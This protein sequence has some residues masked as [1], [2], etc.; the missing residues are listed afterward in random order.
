MSHRRMRLMMTFLALV[1]ALASN[2]G[3]AGRQTPGEKCAITKLKATFK[4]ATAKG[5]CYQKAVAAN[6]AVDPKCLTKAEE[7][8]L[9]SF[10]KAEAKGGCATTGD[11]ASIEG[12]VDAFVAQVVNAL[13]PNPTTSTTSTTTTTTT[14]PACGNA[15]APLCNG[16]CPQPATCAFVISSGMCQCGVG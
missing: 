11:A 14:L 6:L 8:F 10:Q 13:P 9:A 4:K 7:A 12:I 15:A 3:H 16:A 1:A 5:T 2:P